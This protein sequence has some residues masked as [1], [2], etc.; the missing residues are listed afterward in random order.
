MASVPLIQFLPHQPNQP[1][2]Q[3]QIP[4]PNECCCGKFV[5]YAKDLQGLQR[6]WTVGI[7]TWS[8]CG[9]GIRSQAVSRTVNFLIDLIQTTL[10]ESFWPVSSTTYGSEDW[11]TNG[12]KDGIQSWSWWLRPC[13]AWWHAP[14]A[15]LP[16]PIVWLAL[17]AKQ[18]QQ[19]WKF[20]ENK[21]IN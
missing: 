15:G 9:W 10:V 2:W 1:Q 19:K 11:W 6:Q 8:G 12:P 7:G 5:K 17:R 4:N 14:F 13:C 3:Q 16:P 20:N 18:K 21:A